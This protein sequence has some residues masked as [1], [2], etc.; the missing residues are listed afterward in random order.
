[1]QKYILILLILYC[2]Y[3]I[4]KDHI[5]KDEIQHDSVRLFT[6]IAQVISGIT[7]LGLG[8]HY[9]V[10]G[11]KSIAIVMGFQILDILHDECG[12]PV[13]GRSSSVPQPCVCCAAR[14]LCLTRPYGLR[15]RVLGCTDCCW[16]LWYRSGR[17]GH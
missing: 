12:W 9:F 11:A 2:W 14:P 16:A 8:A 13:P 6:I 5:H 7:G 17:I 1:M 15:F 4:S 3:L 10:L